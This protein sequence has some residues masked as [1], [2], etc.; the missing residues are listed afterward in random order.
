MPI[1]VDKVPSL[2]SATPSCQ[3]FAG[4][5]NWLAGIAPVADSSSQM[6]RISSGPR[7]RVQRERQMWPHT[8]VA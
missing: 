4:E 7:T 5:G 8:V 3:T 6:P 2:A 1:A